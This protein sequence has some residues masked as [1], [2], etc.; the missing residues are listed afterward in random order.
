MEK[1]YV[2]DESEKMQELLKLIG[3]QTEDKVMEDII[4][5]NSITINTGTREVRCGNKP[6]EITFKEYELLVY[7]IKNTSRIV[8]RDE[9]LNQIWGYEYNRKS[10]TLD[11]HIRTLREKLGEVGLHNIRTIRN[12]GYRFIGDELPTRGRIELDKED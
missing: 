6:V 3:C 7:L 11:I 2:L 1:I 5:V 8:Y 10:R 9:L 4:S 12:V